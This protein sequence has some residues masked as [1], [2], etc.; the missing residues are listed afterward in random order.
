MDD[1]ECSGKPRI[2]RVV[3]TVYSPNRTGNDR[4]ASR[5]RAGFAASR[6]EF[7]ERFKVRNSVSRRGLEDPRPHAGSLDA[8]RSVWPSKTTRE[9]SLRI[10]AIRPRTHLS[11]KRRANITVERGGVRVSFA[12]SKCARKGELLRPPSCFSPSFVAARKRVSPSQYR[13]CVGS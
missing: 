2:V 1:R 13:R 3:W 4:D 10:H 9:L 11:R 8:V 6:A 5:R 12:C 7:G